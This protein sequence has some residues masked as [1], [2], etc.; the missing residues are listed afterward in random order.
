MNEW[1]EI[2][3]PYY[4]SEFDIPKSKLKKFKHP[5]FPNFDIK[6][7][8]EF[9]ITYAEKVR[10]LFSIK[11]ETKYKNSRIYLKYDKLVSN[12]VNDELNG[13]RYDKKSVKK[14][15]IRLEEIAKTD[16]DIRAVLEFKEFRNSYEEWREKQI[17]YIEYNK[18]YNEIDKMKFQ[19][20]DTLSFSGLRL[21]KPG[22]LIEV[23]VEGKLKQYLIGDI[24][25]LCGVCNDCVAFDRNTI[26]NRYMI[27][28]KAKE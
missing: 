3:L 25:G 20:I 5:K 16:K 15:K 14:L 8:N 23:E 7:K 10:K 12:I 24:N 1:I 26:V 22:T 17:E 19:F 13:D 4:V 6:A 11:D 9:G 21:N 18:K 28:W 27:V 2:N